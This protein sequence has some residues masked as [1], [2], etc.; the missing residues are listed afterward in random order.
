MRADFFQEALAK[1]GDP[2]VLVSMFW[3]R[4]RMLRNETRPPAE[5]SEILSIE[6]VV[7]REIIDGR[8]VYVLGDI[9]VLEDI[10]GLRIIAPWKRAPENRANSSASPLVNAPIDAMAS[11]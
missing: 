4:L 9:V 5:S 1:V 6:D 10:V 2:D 3:A 7:L 11:T 8:I